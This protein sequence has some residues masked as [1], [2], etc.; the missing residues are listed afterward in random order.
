[1]NNFYIWEKR[2]KK[3]KYTIEKKL[4]ANFVIEELHLNMTKRRGK[5][6]IFSLFLVVHHHMLFV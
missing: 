3:N 6:Q 4:I 5:I 1:M 2:I